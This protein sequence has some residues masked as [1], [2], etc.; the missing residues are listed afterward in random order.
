MNHNINV[1]HSYSKEYVGLY[2]VLYDEQEIK[3]KGVE[4]SLDMM[5][6]IGLIYMTPLLERFISTHIYAVR[7]SS[8]ILTFINQ[9]IRPNYEAISLKCGL[10]FKQGNILTHSRFVFKLLAHL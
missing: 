8:R 4:R 7:R 5:L 6:A 2:L 3:E 9:N 1:T 10:D